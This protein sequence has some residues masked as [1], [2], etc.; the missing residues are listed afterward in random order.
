ME[1]GF[2]ALERAGPLEKEGKTKEAITFYK[3]RSC[4]YQSAR[5]SVRE[6]GCD[7]QAANALPQYRGE[8]IGKPYMLYSYSRY[9][10][11]NSNFCMSKETNRRTIRKTARRADRQADRKTR[12]TNRQT[13]QADKYELVQGKSPKLHPP[14]MPLAMCIRMQCICVILTAVNSGKGDIA[15]FELRCQSW[16]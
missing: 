10:V 2:A 8:T 5:S 11:V 1:R 4:L 12:Q 15:S 13:R 14:G 3:V 16:R 6:I 9:Q 7:R